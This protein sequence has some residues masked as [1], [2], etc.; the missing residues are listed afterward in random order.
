MSDSDSDSDSDQAS[1]MLAGVPMTARIDFVAPMNDEMP[2]S[3]QYSRVL[4]VQSEGSLAAFRE[5]IN[6]S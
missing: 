5:F 4:P 6:K 1:Q 2:I 3:T